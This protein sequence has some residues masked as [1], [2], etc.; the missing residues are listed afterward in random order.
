MRICPVC[1]IEMKPHDFQLTKNVIEIHMNKKPVPF[2]VREG[3]QTIS[4][5]EIYICPECGLIQQYL[6]KEHLCNI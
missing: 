6:R 4:A 2:L 1:N 3:D 5:A